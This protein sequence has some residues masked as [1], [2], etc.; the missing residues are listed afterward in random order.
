MTTLTKSILIVM[1]IT[2]LS[3]TQLLAQEWSEEQKEVWAQV[4]GRW[5]AWV[6]GDY[7]KGISFVADDS[8][9]WR[10]NFHAPYTVKDNKPW[11]ERWLQ[12]NK[13][14]LISLN[15]WAIDVYDD[16]AIVFYSI[17]LVLEQKDG[18]E[19]E[20]Q[21]KWTEIHRNIDGKWLLISHTAFD[22]K[23]STN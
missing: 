14:V 7:N 8:R 16:V 3:S 15:S 23:I 17:Q 12:N 22:F 6:E 13:I 4:E 9:G 18:S 19:K 20:T 21:G 11:L 2:L 1:C 10:E 5:Q